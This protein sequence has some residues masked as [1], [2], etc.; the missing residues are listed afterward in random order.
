MVI[1]AYAKEGDQQAAYWL[2]D[3]FMRLSCLRSRAK[4]WRL[5]RW[6][7]LG[8]FARLGDPETWPYV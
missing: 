1:Q 8:K 7:S 5:D 3:A 6:K 2:D 4:D